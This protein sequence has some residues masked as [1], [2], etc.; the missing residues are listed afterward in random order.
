MASILYG[1]IFAR[2]LIYEEALPHKWLCNSST[3]SFLIYKE[4]WFSFL[5]VC[6]LAI[7]YWW[8]NLENLCFCKMLLWFLCLVYSI[9]GVLKEAHTSAAKFFNYLPRYFV[10]HVGIKKTISVQCKKSFSIFPSPAGMS[11]TK[12]SLARNN[13][14]MTS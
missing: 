2:F 13:L 4:F 7:K 5:S 3:L 12:L 11:L 14:Y 6:L 10:R 8:K 9:H 1:E